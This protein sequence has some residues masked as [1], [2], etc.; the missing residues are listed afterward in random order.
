MD[1]TVIIAQTT[2]IGSDSKIRS[3]VTI[4]I[5]NKKDPVSI[6][7]NAII[8]SHTVIYGGN[9]IGSHFQT[10]HSVLIRENNTIGDFVSIGSH[11]V[12]EHHVQIGNHVRIHTGAF[13]PEYSILENH[14][15]I[16]PHVVLTN[17]RYPQSSKA[18]KEL[19]GPIIKKN[20]RIGANATILPGVIIGR[21]ALVGAGA[22]VTKDVPDKAVVVGNPA[23]IINSITNL[24]YV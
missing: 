24:P 18:K 19:R 2:R 1:S 3:F 13:I 16:G 6:K 12:I 14:C 21:Y 11:T 10:G 20:A 23:R 17:A 5:E 7:N 22:V 8:R 15:W 9:T 4:G